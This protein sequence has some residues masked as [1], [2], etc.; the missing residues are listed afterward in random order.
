MTREIEG[1]QAWPNRRADRRRSRSAA[2]AAASVPDRTFTAA[3]ANAALPL[4]RAIVADLVR[5]SREV[6]ER[7]QR[8]EALLGRPSA[9]RGQ[10]PDP[11]REELAHV[12]QEL[13][14]DAQRLQE[15]VGE[16]RQLGVEPKSAV[17]GLIDFP[18]IVDGQRAY[19]CWKL[20]EAQV[21]FWHE[22][23]TGY[24]GRRALGQHA[25]RS[26]QH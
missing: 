6:V 8:L 16:L 24:Q 5:L 21:L 20:G 4:V 1:G 26:D 11:Y 17:E 9:R 3:E 10:Q 2:S 22:H 7:R 23:D 15:Y 19:L 14:D 18:T 13:E 25:T 12:Q